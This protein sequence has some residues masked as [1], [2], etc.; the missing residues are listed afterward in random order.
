[1]AGVNLVIL[2]QNERL[3]SHSYIPHCPG[4]RG[5]ERIPLL[6]SPSRAKLEYSTVIPVYFLIPG[7][8]LVINLHTGNTL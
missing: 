6:F 2:P 1:M 7:R 3:G 5:K 4:T 8:Q